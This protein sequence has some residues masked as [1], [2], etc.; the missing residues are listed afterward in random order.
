[1]TISS[2]AQGPPPVMFPVKHGAG[3]THRTSSHSLSTYQR[4][5]RHG[6]ANRYTRSSAGIVTLIGLSSS[7]S[8]GAFNSVQRLRPEA[9]ETPPSA[10][11]MGSYASGRSNE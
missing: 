11:A 10:P 8:H 5:S 1:M 2:G 6:S 4:I 7:Q 9:G 3:G